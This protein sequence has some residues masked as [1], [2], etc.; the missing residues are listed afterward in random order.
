MN[1]RLNLRFRVY[2]ND[3]ASENLLVETLGLREGIEFDLVYDLTDSW[4]TEFSRIL[5]DIEI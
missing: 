4:Q 2:G 1:N 5:V 3:F